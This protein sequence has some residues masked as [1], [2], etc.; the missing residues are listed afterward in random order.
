MPVSWAAVT[1]HREDS[2]GSLHTQA[3]DEADRSEGVSRFATFYPGL[4]TSLSVAVYQ[5]SPKPGHLNQQTGFFL[6]AK[7]C[8]ELGVV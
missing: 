2:A 3:D 8:Q 7:E 6:V 1:R 4:H 5:N